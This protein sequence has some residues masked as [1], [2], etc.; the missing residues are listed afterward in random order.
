[1]T[2]TL[3]GEMKSLIDCHLL[4]LFLNMYLPVPYKIQYDTTQFPFRETVLSLLDE[5]S[6]EL[7][8]ITDKID[9]LSRDKD[10]ST[11]WH[12]KY[13]DNFQ[14]KFFSLYQKFIIHLSKCFNYNSII[15]QKIPTFR[16]H[17]VGNLGVGEWHKDKTYNHGSAEINF[18][19]PFTD[20]YGTNTIWSESAEDKKDYQPYSVKYGEVLVFNGANLMHG[21]KIND[22]DKTRVSIDFRLVDPLQFVSN[23]NSSINGITKFTIGGYF[24]QI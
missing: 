3:L 12:R 4:N 11:K 10:Q 23:E 24:E 7:L 6:L 17:Q 2:D 1:M 18:W 5:S 9:L 21:N 15:Y 20:T 22:T 19:L 14:E 16:V 13:Y 8:H